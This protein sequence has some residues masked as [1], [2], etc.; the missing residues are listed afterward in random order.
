M[1][2]ATDHFNNGGALK[3]ENPEKNAKIEK[4]EGMIPGLRPALC[5]FENLGRNGFEPLKA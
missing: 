1:T 4:Q 5:E 3:E 2:L